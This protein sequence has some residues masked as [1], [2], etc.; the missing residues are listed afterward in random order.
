M[1]TDTSEG[2]LER[3]ICKALTGKGCTPPPRPDVEVATAE[4]GGAGWI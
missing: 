1:K 3:I 2:G 4:G